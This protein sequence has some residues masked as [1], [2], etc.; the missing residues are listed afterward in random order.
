MRHITERL[1]LGNVMD[2]EGDIKPA[3]D[4]QDAQGYVIDLPDRPVKEVQVVPASV[5]QTTGSVLSPAQIV[6]REQAI[7]DGYV[8]QI[9]N[10]YPSYDLAKAE[11]ERKYGPRPKDYK[12]PEQSLGSTALHGTQP[13]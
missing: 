6:A 2:S 11:V 12:E 7:W 4:Y 8:D 5:E 10:S 13:E 1:P 3:A 9:E